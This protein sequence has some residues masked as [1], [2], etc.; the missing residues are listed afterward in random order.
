MTRYEQLLQTII[1]GR[2]LPAQYDGY[3]LLL[4]IRSASS[5]YV[6]YLYS[7]QIRK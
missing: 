4:C 1:S 6:L 7:I 5:R 3:G 2:F